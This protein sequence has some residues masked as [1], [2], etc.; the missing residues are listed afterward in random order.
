[1]TTKTKPE[2]KDE[3]AATDKVVE[4]LAAIV[5]AIKDQTAVL[6]VIAEAVRKL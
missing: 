2:T 1:M 4:Q 3:P 6:K 5:Q